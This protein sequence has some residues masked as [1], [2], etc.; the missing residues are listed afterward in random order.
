MV[1]YN[2]TEK[3]KLQAL[4]RAMNRQLKVGIIELV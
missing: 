3:Q 2:L 1:N 4:N